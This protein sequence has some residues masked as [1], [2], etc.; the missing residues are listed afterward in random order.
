MS[1]RTALRICTLCEATCGLELEIEGERVVRVRGDQQDV[2]SGGYLCPKGT[3]IGDLHHDPDRLRKPL[4]KRNGV[5]EEVEWDEAFRVVE[6]GLGA[7]HEAGGRDA[8][9]VYLGNPNVHN[10]SGG[11]YIR[12]LLRAL[13]TKNQFSASTVDQMPRHVASGLMFGSPTA[14]AVPDLDRTDYLLMLGAN[15]LESNGSLLTAPDMPGRLRDLRKR[16]GRLVVVDP[17]RT[18]TAERADEHLAILPGTDAHFLLAIAR[19]L[20]EEELVDVG[21]LAE[22][23]AELDAIRGVLEP[24][25]LD[26]VSARCG[27]PAET[28]TRIARELAAAPRA[29]VYG[30]IGTNT[31]SF[32]TLNA[33]A[34]DL[35]NL[36]TGNLDRVGGAMFPLP[37]HSGP[38]P[39]QAKPGRGFQL[40]RWKSRVSGHPEALSEF[41]VAALAEEI[42]TEGEGQVRALVTVAG[43]PVLSTPDS[44]RLDRALGTLD[45]MVSVDLYLNE[46][47]RHADVIL[48]TPSPLERPYYSLAFSGAMVRNSARYSPAVF[49]TDMPREGEI[50]ARLALIAGGQ[51]ADASPESVDALLLDGLLGG[52]AEATGR[53]LDELRSAVAGAGKRPPEVRLLD[54]LLRAGAYGDGFGERAEGLSVEALERAPHGIDFGPLEPSIPGLLRTKSGRIEVLPG[55]IAEDLPR[56]VADLERSPAEGFVL[57]SRRDLRSNNSWMHN[58]PK[59]VSGADRCTLHVHPED[60]AELGLSEGTRARVASRVGDVEVPVEITDAVRRGVVCLPHGW[61]HDLPGV[62]LGVAS[63]HAGVNTNRLT[64]GAVLDP[65]SG[66]A[67][68]NGIPVEVS[69]A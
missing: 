25:T 17:R 2:L 24:F 5:H 40:G 3:A 60:A 54:G 59:L 58:L 26:A 33:W 50:L 9:A 37:P 21:R 11:L 46:T 31:V 18:R 41:P 10:L 19:V 16:G 7:V 36:L 22:H 20:Y 61:G 29:A 51:G 4:V 45:F 39:E 30:R 53:D 27:V 52:V 64:D 65:L 47:T 49:E 6:E 48:P 68:L 66:N 13:G 55:P 57:V 15:P 12:P 43:N 67:A 28:I 14:F 56:L 32:G 63:A 42:E 8:V 35:L 44:E 23:C 1:T 38:R 62:R 69:A 34:V